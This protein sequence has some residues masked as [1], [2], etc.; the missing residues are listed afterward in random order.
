MVFVGVKR[1]RDGSELSRRSFAHGRLR[2]RALILIVE[3]TFVDVGQAG[4]FRAI[5]LV[6]LCSMMSKAIKFAALYLHLTALMA[7]QSLRLFEEIG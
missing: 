6:Y 7:C 4:V 1:F 2:V 5:P 3:S